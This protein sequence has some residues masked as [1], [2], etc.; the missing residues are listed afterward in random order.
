[1][2]PQLA[3]RLCGGFVEMAPPEVLFPL[4][5]L[6]RPKSTNLTIEVT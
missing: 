4:I 6:V 5:N 2:L 3:A 1:M